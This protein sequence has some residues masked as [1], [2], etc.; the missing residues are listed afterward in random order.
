MP[1]SAKLGYLCGRVGSTVSDHETDYAEP[2]HGGQQPP[3]VIPSGTGC[4]I[5]EKAMSPA[6]QGRS[7]QPADSARQ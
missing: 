4:F 5:Y 7:R 1:R 6:Y 3:V 2:T